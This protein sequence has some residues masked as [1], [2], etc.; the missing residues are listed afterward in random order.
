VATLAVDGWGRYL[1]MN[2]DNGAEAGWI[3]AQRYAFHR[4]RHAAAYSAW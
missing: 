3:A 4:I 2:E 1:I